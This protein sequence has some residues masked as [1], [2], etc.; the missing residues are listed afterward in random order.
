VAAPAGAA[1]I[2]LV[3]EGFCDR[4]YDARGLLVPR[5]GVGALVEEPDAV[6]A[7]ARALAVDRGVASVDGAW[8]ALDVRTLCV[9]GDGPGAVARARAVRVALA[10]AGVPVRAF[11][12]DPA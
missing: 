2:R 8:V 3:A 6:G 1:G 5:G 10:R 11:A 9:H 7:R 4:G 12:T